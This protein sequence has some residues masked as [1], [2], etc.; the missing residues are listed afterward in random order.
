MGLAGIANQEIDFRGA[1][2]G[3]ILAHVFLPVEADTIKSRLDQFADLE[4]AIEKWRFGDWKDVYGNWT[5]F[6]AFS[7]KFGRFKMPLLRISAGQ[8]DGCGLGANAGLRDGDVDQE[9]LA[10]NEY[11][12]AE[13]RTFASRKTRMPGGQRARFF[14]RARTAASSASP[15]SNSRTRCSL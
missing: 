4:E 5:T 2:Q 8:G 9:L 12:A 14:R 1:K 3:L 10:R 11:L 7:V 15:S 13:N 6:D